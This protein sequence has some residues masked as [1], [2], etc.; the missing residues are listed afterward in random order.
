MLKHFPVKV[1]QTATHPDGK[2]T[3]AVYLI[4]DGK[5]FPTVDHKRGWSE[6]PQ[7]ELRPNGLFY[8]TCF[9]PLGLSET[10]DYQML[11]NG[12]LH[13]TDHHPDGATQYPVYEIRD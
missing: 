8:R 6:L 11:K 12:T 5:L 2:S 4:E 10:P 13:R 3:A 7:Y 9:H 1:F